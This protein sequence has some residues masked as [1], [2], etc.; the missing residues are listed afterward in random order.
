M[1][2]FNSS[3]VGDWIQIGASIGVLAGILFLFVALI[4]SQVSNEPVQSKPVVNRM[5]VEQGRIHSVEE[6]AEVTQERQ[7]ELQRFVAQNCS[8]CHGLTGGIGPTLSKA[9]LQHLSLNAVTFTI[10][11][12]R[13]TKG[14]PPWGSQISRD[15]AYWIAEFLKRN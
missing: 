5:P 2:R 10:L 4:L 6:S 1:S 3:A 15:D 7:G 12:G 14:M 9:N 13:T 8:P 11:Y